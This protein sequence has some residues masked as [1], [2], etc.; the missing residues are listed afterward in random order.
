MICLRCGYCCKNLAVVIVKD[1]AL[2]IREDNLIPHNFDGKKEPCPHLIEKS[3][4]TYECKI[5]NEPW[6]KETPCYQYTQ[7]E[8]GNQPC[9]IGKRMLRKK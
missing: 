2:G 1:P 8:Q 7:I 5:H 6:F 4:G 9:R 3:D